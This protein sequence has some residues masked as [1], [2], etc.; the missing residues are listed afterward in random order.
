M[1]DSGPGFVRAR[2]GEDTRFGTSGLIEAIREAARA[3]MQRFAG[4]RPIRVGD[5]SAPYGGRHG[6]HHSHRSGRD[7]DI[8]YYAMDEG[9]APIDGAGFFAYDRFGVARDA[10]DAHAE[11]QFLDEARNWHFMRTLLLDDERPIQWIFCSAGVKTR[12]LTWALAHERNPEVLWRATYVLHQPTDGRPHDDHFHI[13]LA[14]TAQTRAEGCVD[15]GP[16]WPWFNE[17]TVKPAPDLPFAN[18]DAS[19]IHA[20]L[21]D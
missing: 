19:L 2:P 17:R 6:R 12:L 14:C 18:D 13:R 4:T 20:L 15:G 3:V 5:L 1:P 16:V 7:A 9:G 21:D 10:R 11:L 8:I